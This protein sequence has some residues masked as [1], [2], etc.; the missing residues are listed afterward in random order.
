MRDVKEGEKYFTPSESKKIV[1]VY[2]GYTYF[3]DEDVLLAKVTPCFEN[4]KS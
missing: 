1:E 3:S 4:G 2:S